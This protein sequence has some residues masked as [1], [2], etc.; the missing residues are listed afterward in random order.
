MPLEWIIGLVIL[1]IVLAIIEV[2]IPGIGAFAILSV[3]S[4]SASLMLL[5]ITV[6]NLAISLAASLLL[7]AIVVGSIVLFRKSKG[8]Y[9]QTAVQEKGAKSLEYLLGEEATAYS[10]LRPAGTIEVNGELYDAI[11]MGNII[12]KGERVKIIRVDYRK[13]FVRALKEVTKM[14]GK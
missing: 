9:L 12:E 6:N 4:F 3:I 13:I 2:F 7:L 14:E 1:G 11:S 10:V 8:L 5:I